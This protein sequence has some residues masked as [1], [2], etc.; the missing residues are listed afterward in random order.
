MRRF[1]WTPIGA[2]GAMIFCA[3]F[4][5]ADSHSAGPAQSTAAA[6]A[7]DAGAVQPPA[8]RVRSFWSAGESA[9]TRDEP[10][11]RFDATAHYA[12]DS[13][14]PAAPAGRGGSA[15]FDRQR[16]VSGGGEVSQAAWV[17]PVSMRA[18][19]AGSA[20]TTAADASAGAARDKAPSASRSRP[21]PLSPRGSGAGPPG[22]AGQG[23]AAPWVTVIGSLAV[24]LGL[25]FVFAWALRRTAPRGSVALP[26][27]VFE[28][29][30]RAPLAG[31]QEV[32]LVRC[33]A[34]L[35]LVSVTPAGAE[36]LTEI[37]EP[38]EVD[39]LAGLCQQVRPG[40]ATATF[41][42]VLHQLTGYRGDQFSQAESPAERPA[43]RGLAAGTNPAWEARDV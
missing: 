23:R 7:T 33:G 21:L 38:A 24:V 11:G 13:G 18:T 32:H 41:R 1:R 26:S 36:T 17:A 19:A 20:G 39:R 5:R 22:E 8:P 3:G 40:S 29:L 4:V 16:A 6:A 15:A 9:P 43:A 37:T 30:G 42:E 2:V 10:P 28:V 27:E 14:Y 31:R 25:F 12:E 34:K 35:L